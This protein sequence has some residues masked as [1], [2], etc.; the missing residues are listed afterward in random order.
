MLLAAAPLWA[1]LVGLTGCGDFWQAPSSDSAAFTLT[2]SG[3]TT[4]AASSTVTPT[5]TVTPT[6]SFTGTVSL[7]CS[8]SAPS[9]ATDP[10]TCSLSPTS[11]TISGTSAETS[12]MTVTSGTSLGAYEITVTGVSG[13]VA[14]TTTVCVEVG[15]GSCTSTATTSGH[16]YILNG[17][18]TT[19][20]GS[21]AGFTASASSGSLTAISNSSYTVTGGTAVAMAPSGA[22]LYVA[23]TSGGLTL[24]SI[25]QSTGA[26]TQGASFGDVD[27]QALQI[28]QTDASNA[29]LLDTTSFGYLNAYPITSAG[30]LDSSR[31]EQSV[32]LSLGT[33]AVERGGM[34][35]SANGTLIA[36][37]LGSTG[38]EILT[39]SPTSTSS[40]IVSSSTNPLSPY[41]SGGAA[42]SV[43]FDPQSRFLYVGETDAYT[44]SGGLRTFTIGSGSL[45]ALGITS[46]GGLAPLAILADPTGS[47]VYVANGNGDASGDAG[48]V[49]E[50]TVSSSSG[51]TAGSTVAAGAQPLGLAED[52]TG[53][54]IFEVGET[55]SPYFD[56]YTLSDG[57]LTSQITSTTAATS[58]AIV[59]AP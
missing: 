26:L 57:A 9:G 58:I 5:I 56:A 47:Y 2:N 41:N 36:V 22:F 20:S 4:V 42:I 54:Y 48:N 30:A 12:T 35:V 17:D 13:S 51:L 7:T 31:A 15:S 8:V 3:N 25:N 24:Y 45:T 33:G 16:F 46:S 27:A 18:S 1:G 23:S 32:P 11:V 28:V 43:A 53:S 59:A 52:S 10:A 21:I 40:P 39:F 14:E 37:A 6:N 44:S 29:W 55:G 49:A 50:F 34:A 38:T 19:G